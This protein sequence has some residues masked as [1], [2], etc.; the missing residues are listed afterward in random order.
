MNIFT[1]TQFE[2]AYIEMYVIDELI[3]IFEFML[4]NN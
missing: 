1:E 3:L 4:F 2:D